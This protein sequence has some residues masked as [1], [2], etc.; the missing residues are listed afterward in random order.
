MKEENLWKNDDPLDGAAVK[1]ATAGFTAADDPA[2][3]LV[4]LLQDLDTDSRWFKKALLNI[5]KIEERWSIVGDC[6]LTICST[7]FFLLIV[8]F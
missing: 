8:V 4:M 7:S 5:S 2:S 1:P 3:A 6:G